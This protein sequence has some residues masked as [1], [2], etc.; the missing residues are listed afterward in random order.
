MEEAVK[1][2]SNTPDIGPSGLVLQMPDRIHPLTLAD[3]FEVLRWI[4]GDL[5]QVHSAFGHVARIRNEMTAIKGI[6]KKQEAA[7]KQQASRYGEL[8]SAI[9]SQERRIEN[10]DQRISQLA[11]VLTAT[12]RTMIEIH[13]KFIA[14]EARVGL[15]W[16]KKLL[17]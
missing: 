2:R 5:K 3:L 8:V 13:G 9:T 17:R 14:I 11:D 12:A 1:L 10:Q 15:P 7:Y 6:H 16:W 4:H